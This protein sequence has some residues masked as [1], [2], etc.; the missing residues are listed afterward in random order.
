MTDRSKRS[1]RLKRPAHRQT[2]FS[3]LILAISAALIFAAQHG[4]GQTQ[5]AGVLWRQAL[6]GQ[7]LG[8]PAAEAETVTVVCD[9]GN[10]K[11][12]TRQG[13]IL[14]NFKVRGRLTPFISRSPEGTSY[15]CQTNGVFIAVNRAGRELWR[16]SL[17]SPIVAPTLVGWDGRIFVFTSGAETV[18]SPGRPG[19][20]ICYTASGNRLWSRSLNYPLAL[21]PCSDPGGG[22]ILLLENGELLEIDPFGLTYSRKL[23]VAPAVI[24][25][26][27]HG[28]I[29]TLYAN[30]NAAISLANGEEI[31]LPSLNGVPAAAITRGNL[32]AVTLTNGRLLLFGPADTSGAEPS[33]A[34]STD[35][36]TQA[37]ESA[38]ELRW[39][40]ETH[41]FQGQAPADV[42]MI[43][44]DRGIYVLTQTGASG[45]TADGRRLWV[46]QLQSAST[47]PALSDEGILYSGGSDW[48]LYAY[49]LEDRD[50]PQA[51]SI[52]G[53]A[54]KG[55]Y[56]IAGPRSGTEIQ[57]NL[58]DQELRARFS[59][60]RARV[61]TGTVGEAEREYTA[62]LM[63]I[64]DSMGPHPTREA[65][66]HPRVS[67]IYRTEA[68][69]LLGII[70]SRE[71]IP[72]LAGLYSYDQDSLIKAAAAEAIGSIGVDPEGI[73]LRAFSALVFPPIPYRDEQALAATAAAAGALCRFSGP[74]LSEDGIKLL[75]ALAAD[76][77]PR[78]VRIRAR[79]ELA[80]LIE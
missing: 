20:V 23:P 66:Q 5:A 3:A 59:Q 69:R 7:A 2:R 41:F 65:R 50:R 33:V 79:Q 28:A 25:P 18:A 12:F 55:S 34:T 42:G 35:T 26:M 13:T 64:A 8:P 19:T 29:L 16:H 61:G 10:L 71:T 31:P 75:V 21:P 43:F 74:P 72:F 57:F 47:L 73:A 51:R 1:G 40:G 48:I 58:D 32:V 39:T 53:P 36:E 54:P 17:G 56:G 45:F 62:Y 67:L 24:A 14:W 4:W 44:D 15:I 52:Y 70:G 77:R 68:L 63:E 37:A 80:S 78:L 76:D 9:G 30:G 27:G 6:G 22:F 38:W 46:F 49:H 11:S 60:I